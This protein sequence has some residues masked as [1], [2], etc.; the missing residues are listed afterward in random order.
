M[1]KTL[2]PENILQNSLSKPIFNL[3][4][5]EEAITIC[6]REDGD[7]SN[8]GLTNTPTGGLRNLSTAIKKLASSNTQHCRGTIQL[9]VGSW[10]VSDVDLTLIR[11]YQFVL[12]H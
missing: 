11:N 2:I 8:D 10:N 6:V 9:G 1:L 3:Q 7:D 12:P 4:P 5:I